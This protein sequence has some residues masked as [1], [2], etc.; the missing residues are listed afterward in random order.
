M[1]NYS[2]SAQEMLLSQDKMLKSGILSLRDYITT[3]KY[4]GWHK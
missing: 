3:T 2:K 1:A 4:N